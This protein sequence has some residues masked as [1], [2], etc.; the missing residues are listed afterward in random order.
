MSMIDTLILK[1]ATEG[2]IVR[3]PVTG[4]PLAAEG[5]HK[6]FSKYWAARLRDGDVVTTAFD[7]IKPKTKLRGVE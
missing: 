4:R 1:P 7:E 6:P 2:L 5:E 3:D